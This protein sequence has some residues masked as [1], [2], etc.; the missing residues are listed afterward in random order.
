[1]LSVLSIAGS[2]SSGGAGIQADIKTIAA[3]HLFAQ[4]AITALTAQNTLGVAAV[5]AV[6][7]SMVQDQID[8]VYA[9][10]RPHAVKVGMLSDPQVVKAVA[11]A[12]VRNNATN[13]VLDP[14]MVATSGSALSSNESVAALV[15]HLAP[16]A[17]VLTPNLQEAQVLARMTIDSPEAVEKAAQ[18]ILA[19]GSE[20]VLV[21]GGHFAPE[22]TQASDY[23]IVRNA[24]GC[25]IEGPRVNNPN[26]HGT[27]CTL[28]SAIA[29]GL[30]KGAGIRQ[31]VEDAKRYL[32]RAL[33]ANLNL[34]SG[35]GPLDHLW[36]LPQ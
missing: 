9:D 7:P 28:S 2:D 17:A 33:Q 22:S 31:A 1:M 4:T 12:L 18:A 34:G 35:S 8:A 19:L 23:L 10:I 11:A 3:H 36:M 5:H 25:W 27:G 29:C 21:K 14:V 16:M 20:S 26:T 6:P 15:E 13:I 32:T 30:A 24:G